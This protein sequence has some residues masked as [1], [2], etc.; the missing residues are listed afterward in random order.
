MCI[1]EDK[2]LNLVSQILSRNEKTDKV[3][4]QKMNP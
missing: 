4:P 2:E 3:K 1:D